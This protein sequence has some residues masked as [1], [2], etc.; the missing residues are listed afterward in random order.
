MLGVRAGSN[1]EAWLSAIS[2]SGEL[3]FIRLR[4]PNDGNANLQILIKHHGEINKL[5]ILITIPWRK[6]SQTQRHLLPE[7][8][9]IHPQMFAEY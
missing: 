7:S 5:T 6:E 3:Q 8:L 4:N 1:I 9:H 2:R